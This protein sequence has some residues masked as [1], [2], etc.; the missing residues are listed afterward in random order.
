[1][2]LSIGIAKG[3]FQALFTSS[4]SSPSFFPEG[5]PGRVV[6]REDAIRY[7]GNLTCPC[8]SLACEG[9]GTCGLECDVG[10]N[11]QLPEDLG[12]F[13]MWRTISP[14]VGFDDILPGPGKVTSCISGTIDNCDSSF[15][16]DGTDVPRTMVSFPEPWALISSS[17]V[18]FS[19]L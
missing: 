12:P 15:V 3:G 8:E 4:A 9:G 19:G 6:Y 10:C 16:A 18:G 7:F 11:N 17:P 2:M 14:R 5:M 1:M 13:Y